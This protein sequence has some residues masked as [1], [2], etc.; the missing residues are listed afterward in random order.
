MKST[1]RCCICVNGAASCPSVRRGS[2]VNCTASCPWVR[3]GSPLSCSFSDSSKLRFDM[4][5]KLHATATG[6]GDGQEQHN[7]MRR[8][9]SARRQHRRPGRQGVVRGLRKPRAHLGISRHGLVARS[10]STFTQHSPGSPFLIFADDSAAMAAE[11]AAGRWVAATSWRCVRHGGRDAASA[12]QARGARGAAHPDVEASRRP[13][14]ECALEFSSLRN[15]RHLAT[16]F[17]QF[18]SP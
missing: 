18:I 2:C 8:S 16:S 13:R 7:V 12:R 15:R 10:A 1:I 3:R 14:R 11:A 9:G 4:S 17:G 5:Y 6:S